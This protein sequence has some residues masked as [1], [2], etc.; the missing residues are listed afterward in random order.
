MPESEA[1]NAQVPESG[2]KAKAKKIAKKPPK[3]KPQSKRGRGAQAHVAFPKHAIS[4]CL[5]IPEAVLE[6]NAGKECTYRE[7]AKFAGVGYTGQIGVEISSALKYGLFERTSPGKIKPT[8]LVRRIVRPQ[9]PTDKRNALREAVL[10]APGISDAYTHYRGENMPDITFLRN[11]VID[12]L[13]V[14]ADNADEFMGVFVQSLTDADLLEDVSGKQRILD[15]T[16]SSDSPSTA[17]VVSSDEHLK[18]VAK[19]LS[20]QSTD[21]CFVMMP[22][23]EPLGS[24]YAKIYEPAIRKAG[25]NPKRADDDIFGT[26]KIIDQIWSG[27]NSARVLVAELTGRNP[28]VLYE[29]GLS[30]AIKKPV[31]LVSANENDVPFDV[32]HVRVIYY[33]MTDPFWGSKLIDKVAE[34]ILSALKNP[35]EAVLFD[36]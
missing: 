12:V 33:D 10:K 17:S 9:N 23:A 34:N 26:G 27:I 16:H 11:T 6:Q 5:R 31:V 3:K 7:A 18:K 8:E 32:K 22:F 20:V 25:L 29:L 28:N 13:K 15:V 21:T 19:A 24:Y 35:T 1:T 30:H 4:N 2:S 14:P 36:K